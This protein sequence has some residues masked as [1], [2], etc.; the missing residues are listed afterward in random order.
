MH[1]RKAKM[2]ELADAFIALPGGIGTLE[3][4]LEV[5]TWTKLGIHDKPCGVLDV[6]GYWA[7]LA[8]M[9][10]GAVTEEFISAGDRGILNFEADPERLI[11]RLEGWTAPARS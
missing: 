5:T 1:E 11:G 8:A 4:L 3:E 10:D 9:L 7:P 2:A 6:G